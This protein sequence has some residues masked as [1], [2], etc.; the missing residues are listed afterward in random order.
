V[1]D[2]KLIDTLTRGVKAEDGEILRARSCRLLRSGEKNCWIEVVLDEGKNRQIRRMLAVLG[3]GVLR[4][5]RISV[6]PLQLGKLAKGAYRHLTTGEK[7]AIDRAMK[8][9]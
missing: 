6:G 2:E 9:A 4:L 3:I 8:K 7:L 5:V 1:A